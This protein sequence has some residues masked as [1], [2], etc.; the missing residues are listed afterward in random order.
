MSVPVAIPALL[1]GLFLFDLSLAVWAFFLPDLWFA[2]FHG[3]PRV[4][5][6][7]FLPRCGAAWAA[8]SLFQLVAALRWKRHPHWLAVVAGIR[9]SDALT[10]W[11][12]LALCHDVTWFG[13]AS[14][15]ATSPLNALL[16]WY[17][18]RVYAS[19]AAPR[20]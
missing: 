20:R 18:L 9:L 6:Q 19:I 8:F 1:Y 7:A 12:Y 2:A 14:L 16:G 5:P 15:F 13:R 11:T 3:V 10:D 17:L 4:D